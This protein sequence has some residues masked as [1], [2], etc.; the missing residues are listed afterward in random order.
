MFYEQLM[1]EKN[2]IKKDRKPSQDLN[3]N[4]KIYE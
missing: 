4:M 1:N 3:G 2:K